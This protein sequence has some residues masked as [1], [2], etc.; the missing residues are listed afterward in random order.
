MIKVKVYGNTGFE[1]VNHGDE[2]VCAG[3]SALTITAVNF[4]QDKLGAEVDC[5]HN[6]EGGLIRF[7]LLDENPQAKLILENLVYGLE[8]IKETYPKE[9]KIRRFDNYD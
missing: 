2:I 3:I 6:P 1:V 7:K 9:I 4:I 5:H 8:L